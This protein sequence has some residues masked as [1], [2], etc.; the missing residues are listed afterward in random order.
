MTSTATSVGD[1][2]GSALDTVLDTT[3]TAV[4]SSD[5]LDR[6]GAAVDLDT[7]QRLVGGISLGLGAA[8]VL[9]P[10]AVASGFG[11]DAAANPALTLLTRFIGIRNATMGS[12]LLQAEDE[13]TVRRA[14]A[15]G[16]AVGASDVVAVA[17]AVRSGVLSKKAGAAALLLLGGIAVVGVAGLRD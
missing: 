11:V 7:A 10:R 9:A 15:A 16:L 14:L 1:P 12:G 6:L 13:A 4:R 8:A 3:V 17:L 2:V 5:L